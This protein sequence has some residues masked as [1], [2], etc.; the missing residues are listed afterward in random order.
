MLVFSSIGVLIVS[1]LISWA[2]TNVRSARS[3][4]NEELALQIAESGINYYRWHL[5]H[6]PTDYQDGT[7]TSGPYTHNFY[8]K[9]GE[10]I[11]KFSL[12]ITP[13]P[14]GSTI[15]TVVSEGTLNNASSSRAIRA[16]LAIPSL[17]KYAIVGNS[18]LRFGEGTEVYGPIHSNGG[19]R[20]DG[21]AYNVVTSAESNYSD[22]DHTGN[23]EF[24]VHTHVD[25]PPGS[26]VTGSFRSAEA[27]PNPIPSRLDVF[28]AGRQFPVAP[29][30]F[31]GIT[32]DLA[33]IKSLAQS[34]GRYIAPSG[35]SGYRIIFKTNDTFDVYRVNSVTTVT[36]SCRSES[37]PSND[38]T[39]G[40]WTVN[41][42]SLVGNYPNPT[43]GLIFVEDNAWVGGQINSARITLVAAKFPV[44]GTLPVITVNENLSYTNYDGTDVLALIA[45]GDI[46]V[47]LGSPNSLE[48]DG[49]LISQNG[50]VGRPYYDSACGSNYVR[51][52]I[53]LYGMLG[54]S[55]RYG[56]AYTDGTGYQTRTIS[57]DSNMLY[58]PPPS[59]PLTSDQYEIISWEEID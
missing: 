28:K 31:T 11:G 54:S 15:V 43:N 16:Q 1:A 12:T 55:D 41:T 18:D 5:A 44:P 46:N 52:S 24:G 2:G 53:A 21:V 17:A 34:A 30:D 3:A 8:D 35:R 58:A 57:Y 51:N 59:F 23:N 26:G 50:R 45:Q 29:V 20:F 7:A 14:I 33:S 19:I 48:I 37:N 9:D 39:W 32:S 10:A 42:Q 25:P 13:P 49:A 56:F 38:P 36:S 27:P 47:G 22:P 4:R 6:A 40:S